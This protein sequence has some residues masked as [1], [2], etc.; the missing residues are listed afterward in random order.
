MKHPSPG[1]ALR[2]AIAERHWNQSELAQRTGRSKST[3]C[4]VL[5]DRTPISV[6][7]DFDLHMVLGTPQGYWLQLS[8][9][10]L[11]ELRGYPTPLEASSR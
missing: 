10:W 1:T 11:A 9:R 4:R 6:K 7:M 3:I 8:N 5:S 2:Q